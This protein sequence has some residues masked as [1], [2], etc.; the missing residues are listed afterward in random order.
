MITEIWPLERGIALRIRV[1]C[2]LDVLGA[3]FAKQQM[4]VAQEVEDEFRA[5]GICAS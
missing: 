1:V 4:S 5:L 2:V 3:E